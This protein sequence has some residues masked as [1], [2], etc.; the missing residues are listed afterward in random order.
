[1]SDTPTVE[2]IVERLRP[3]ARPN[4]L[5]GMARF[6]IAT[7]HALGVSMPD[8]RAMG[9]SL[10]RNHALALDL[11]RTPL[12]ETRILASLVADPQQM[13]EELMEAWARDFADWE[14]CD[15]CCFNLFGK[16]PFARHFALEWSGAEPEFVKRAG[17]VLM[18]RIAT[19]DKRADNASFE[20][21]FA[22]ITRES[23]DQRNYV[24]KA[25]N[26]ALRQIGKRNRVLNE[27]AVAVARTLAESEN[28]TARW[29]GSDA[30]RELTSEAVLARLKD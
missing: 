29:I 9:K 16:T 27:R 17:F 13:T 11:W 2:E 23:G 3:L 30:L 7:E 5:E 19:T 22:L 18:A 8:L 20:P 26:W 1:M 14:V 21:L 4:A 10:G 15:Q 24:R 12:R 6:G 28:K 25:V